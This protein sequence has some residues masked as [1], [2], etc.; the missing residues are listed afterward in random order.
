MTGP[1]PKLTPRQ[2]QVM[3]GLLDHKR[4]KTIADDLQLSP[5][6]VDGY[7]AEAVALLEARDRAD[8]AVRYR[9]L[10]PVRRDPGEITEQPSGVGEDAAP[11]PTIA[12][13]PADEKPIGRGLERLSA[14]HRLA[15][16]AA[17]S[18]AIAL[19]IGLSAVA[20][21]GWIALYDDTPRPS[22]KGVR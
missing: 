22:E 4:S 1:A 2:H 7:I 20:V 5:R 6:T 8:A 15:I 18:V 3:Q 17:I 10:F 16:I 13:Q 12:P 14:L 11:P 19:G 21:V 9:T